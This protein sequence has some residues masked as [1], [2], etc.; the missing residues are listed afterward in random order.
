M[1]RFGDPY[2]RPTLQLWADLPGVE[3][4]LNSTGGI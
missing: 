4:R 2:Q 3:L 1:L